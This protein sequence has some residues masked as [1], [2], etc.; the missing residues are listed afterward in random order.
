MKILITA[1]TFA[2]SLDGPVFLPAN[3][4]AE[5][6]ED[7]ARGIVTGGKGLHVDRK[8]DKTKLK[9]FTA[10]AEQ[11]EAARQAAEAEAKAAKKA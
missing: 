9:S 8:D 6:D 3:A 7:T 2:P 1:D 4:I 11:I 10:S 5:M